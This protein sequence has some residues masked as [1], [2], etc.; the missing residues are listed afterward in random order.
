[1]MADRRRRQRCCCSRFP[2][3]HRP[4]A[5]NAG[6]KPQA[7]PDFGVEVLALDP[8]YTGPEVQRDAIGTVEVHA[9]EGAVRKRR[10][11]AAFEAELDHD[12]PVADA[13]EV[14]ERAEVFELLGLAVEFVG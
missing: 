12:R 3:P 2:N 6:Q 5:Q 10:R 11:V 13:A 9:R 4:L 7:R 8:H 14:A 1:M